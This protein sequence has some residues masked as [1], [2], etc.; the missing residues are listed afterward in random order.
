VLV[1]KS[2]DDFYAKHVK[3]DYHRENSIDIEIDKI[4]L[5]FIMPRVRG[6]EEGAKK[7]YAGI[8]IDEKG[9]RRLDATGLEIVRRDWTDLAKEFQGKMLELVFAKEDPVAYVKEF[10]Q[11]LKDGKLDDK[12]M[13]RKAIRKELEG[14]TKTTPPHVKAARKLEEAG[15]PLTSSLI[16]YVMTVD[17]PEPMQ[18]LVKRKKKEIDYEHYIDKQLRPI[19]DAILCFYDTSFDDI[20]KGNSQKTLFGY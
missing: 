8:V 18:L 1:E 14:Y 6:S 3:T 17:G 4:F 7:R 19:A 20:L 11:G 16:E 2:I 10:V 5:D 13:Y 12:L 15:I 9:E